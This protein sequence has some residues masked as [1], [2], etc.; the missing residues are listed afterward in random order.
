MDIL[1]KRGF[2]V[3]QHVDAVINSANGFLLLGTS[4]AGR[5]R[6]KSQRLTSGEKRE[7]AALLGKLPECMK[8]DYLRVYR[9]QRWTPTY[10]QLGCLRILVS[11]KGE[12]I[13]RGDAV[14]QRVWSKTD[15]RPV[16]H[17]VGMS[18]KLCING[19]RRLKAT[20]STLAGA[21]RKALRL[22]DSVGAKSIALPLMCARPTYGV[23]PKESLRIIRS[24]F[25]GFRAKNIN[26]AVICFDNSITADYLKRVLG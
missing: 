15:R 1:Y 24:V 2:A 11:R 10:A 13:R 9:E 20:P 18:Y 26:K 22:A 12:E 23:G 8:N 4:G 6:K 19:S 7:Y 3:D 16:I 21:L 5:I 25:R 17:A 14:L